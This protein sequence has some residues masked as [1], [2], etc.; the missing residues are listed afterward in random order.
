MREPMGIL[1][2]L[3]KKQAPGETDGEALVS[4]ALSQVGGVNAAIVSLSSADAAAEPRLK[5][6]AI[7]ARNQLCLK[8][9][10]IFSE[11][12]E[13]QPIEFSRQLSLALREIAATNLKHRYYCGLVFSKQMGELSKRLNSLQETAMRLEEFVARD[14]A[15]KK[16]EVEKKALEARMHNIRESISALDTQL[17]ELTAKA[18]EMKT[19]QMQYK[20]EESRSGFEQSAAAAKKSEA[21]ILNA[22][23]SVFAAVSPS[24]RA[25][26]KYLKVSN[27]EKRLLEV[28]A[29]YV[30][31]P[32]KAALGDNKGAS[33]GVILKDL[34][35]VSREL[36][37]DRKEAE[38]VEALRAKVED[39]GFALLAEQL[40]HAYAVN[41][42]NQSSLERA[43]SAK[44]I[45]GSKLEAL[46]KQKAQL[47]ERILKLESQKKELESELQK[48][49]N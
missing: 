8:L 37:L 1:S 33:L 16:P 14:I 9:S 30:S 3:F 28:L 42:E 49:G 44:R 18:A 31:G 36:S 4:Q 32:V 38:K 17:A 10:R 41:A 46:V 13:K 27:L 29:L 6:A 48:T 40:V 5:A 15:A 19:L 21:D 34:K 7:E 45:A 22:E 35:R 12:S 26:K 23:S 47:E 11:L 24:S 43:L 20:D 2:G 25:L 39:G